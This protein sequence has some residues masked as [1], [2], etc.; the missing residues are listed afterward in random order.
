MCVC[1]FTCVCVFVYA[2]LFVVCMYAFACVCV[3]ERC[4]NPGYLDESSCSPRNFSV[5]YQCMCV[6]IFMFVCVFMY[7]HLFVVCMYAYVCVCVCVFVCV[8]VCV[9]VCV[10]VCVYVL[11]CVCVCVCVCACVCMCACVSVCVCVCV[12]SYMQTLTHVWVA[13]S[14]QRNWPGRKKGIARQF[15]YDS[16]YI[17]QCEMTCT[18][19]HPYPKYRSTECYRQICREFSLQISI[20]NTALHQAFILTPLSFCRPIYYRSTECCRAPILLR[21]L[22]TKFSQQISQNGGSCPSGQHPKK[23]SPLL[24]HKATIPNSWWIDSF[25]TLQHT[26]THCNTLQHTAT[27]CNTLQYTATHC[28]TL[29][30]TAAHNNTTKVNWLI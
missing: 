10:C 24:L 27:H 25:N 3:W 11:M 9:R 4:A 6:C 28:N 18:L 26:A 12:Y 21:V 19:S 14:P 22:P 7:A 15:P 23:R 29:Q 20:W 8:C 1:I 17:R 16:S 13:H 5:K 2:D 30:H